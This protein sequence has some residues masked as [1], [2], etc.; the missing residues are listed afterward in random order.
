MWIDRQG[1]VILD[2]GIVESAHLQQQF[3]IGVVWVGIVGNQLD[4]F[5]E[6]LLGVGKVSLLPVGVPENVVGRGIAGGQF[7]RLLVVLDG[8]PRFL[9]AKIVVSQ[10]EL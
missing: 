1:F 4:V 2:K 10:A 8:R 5:L 6:C 3:R 9:L 7:G